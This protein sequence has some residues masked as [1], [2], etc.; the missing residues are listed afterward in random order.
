MNNQH[1]EINNNKE[2]LEKITSLENELSEELKNKIV[3]IAYNA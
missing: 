2:L 3:L 1:A